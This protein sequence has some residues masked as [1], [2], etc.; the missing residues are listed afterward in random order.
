LQI[1]FLVL[2]VKL[3]SCTASSASIERVMSNFGNIHTN[4]RN[5]PCNNTA[6]KFVFC[7]MILRGTAEF[8]Y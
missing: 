7:Y 3:P 5:R 2:A 6:F 1:D 8:G 4:V